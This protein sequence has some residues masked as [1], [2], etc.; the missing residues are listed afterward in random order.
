MTK[1]CKN[2]NWSNVLTMIRRPNS[3]GLSRAHSAATISIDET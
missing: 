2:Q 3:A 1:M